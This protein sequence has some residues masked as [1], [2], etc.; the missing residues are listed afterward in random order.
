MLPPQRMSSTL[1]LGMR[2]VQVFYERPTHTIF[3]QV[4]LD[5]GKNHPKILN[6]HVCMNLYHFIS[7][8]VALVLLRKMACRVTTGSAAA[9]WT[10]WSARTTGCWRLLC[11]RPF[12]E[13][14]VNPHSQ[15]KVSLEL[16][17][18]NPAANEFSVLNLLLHILV[19]SFLSTCELMW[20]PP[21][22]KNIFRIF[23]SSIM[24]HDCSFQATLNIVSARF[25]LASTKPRCMFPW[26]QFCNLARCVLKMYL[27]VS[28]RC[29]GVVGNVMW[30]QSFETRKNTL[31][32]NKC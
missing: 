1:H 18:S 2:T 13:H 23:L 29:A 6:S 28:L 20:P 9:C 31:T 22:F 19:N 15:F 4:L 3:F 27:L 12:G 30:T 16:N 24:T 21:K 25:V 7:R 14:P 11:E 5:V 17:E 10:R 26:A 8:T 32:R